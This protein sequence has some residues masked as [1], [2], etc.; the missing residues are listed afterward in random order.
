MVLNRAFEWNCSLISKGSHQRYNHNFKRQPRQE[1][2]SKTNSEPP[3]R[4]NGSYQNHRHNFKFMHQPKQI[5]SRSKAPSKPPPRRNG[6][7]QRHHQKFFRMSALSETIL[8]K[9][10]KQS[11]SPDPNLS[12]ISTNGDIS[13]G[14]VTSDTYPIPIKNK[15]NVYYVPKIMV[16]MLGLWYPKLK[17]YKNFLIVIR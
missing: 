14:C 17:K 2:R 3:Y 7:Y 16:I 11:L 10:P 13:V 1:N 12:S 9:T 6:S 15:K 5:N 8:E 4:K